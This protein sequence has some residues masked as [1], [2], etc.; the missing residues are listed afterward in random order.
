MNY[1][2]MAF[3]KRRRVIESVAKTKQAVTK[4]F[5]IKCGIEDNDLKLKLNKMIQALCKQHPVKV[6]LTSKQRYIEKAG[7]GDIYQET[8]QK[9][10]A[11][12]KEYVQF[13]KK[14]SGGRGK[15]HLGGLTFFLNPKKELTKNDIKPVVLYGCDNEEN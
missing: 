9:I 6:S 15:R 7:E 8:Q 12:L 11:P 1:S 2:K 4:E 10:I 3:D 5:R 14:G 13:D